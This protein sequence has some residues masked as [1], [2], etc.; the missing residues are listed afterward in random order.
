M[1]FIL[2]GGEEQ[3]LA[4]QEL[5]RRRKES[6]ASG[7]KIEI[8]H[9][10]EIV[11]P[12]DLLGLDQAQDFFAR[13]S[14]VIVYNLLSSGKKDLRTKVEE[15]VQQFVSAKKKAE[16][17]TCMILYETGKVDRRT[18]LYKILKKNNLVINHS[19]AKDKE[20]VA[21]IKEYLWEHN[22][23]AGSGIRNRLEAKLISQNLQTIKYE[24]EKIL[25]LLEQEQRS[26]LEEQDLDII[27]AD[28]QAEI[29]QLLS[30]SL[31]DKPRAYAL[32][33]KLL[34]Q[35]VNYSQIVGYLALELRKLIDYQDFPENLK[36]FIRKR[37]A[38]SAKSLSPTKLRL[39]L[40]K[41]MS[42]D[43]KLK[44]SKIEPRQGLMLYLSI[45]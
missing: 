24:L 25:L 9:A 33:D 34:L 17:T 13:E 42:L 27:Q 35:Q 40:K 18:K 32:L 26:K 28:T 39:A 3:L 45:L 1:Q 6:D 30:Y 15:Q 44:Q 43:Q 11:A 23:E 16:E 2:I 31:T 36:P 22:L 37:V 21:F 41:L 20:K 5:S 29:W 12:N 14:L 4:K 8:L 7:A 10:D 19:A 38:T